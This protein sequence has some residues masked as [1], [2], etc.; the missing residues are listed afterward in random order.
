MN[1]GYTVLDFIQ[2]VRAQPADATDSRLLGRLESMAKQAFSG[3]FVALMAPL[4]RDTREVRVILPGAAVVPT[5]RQSV[6][7]PQPI[8]ILGFNPIVTAAGAGTAPD[9]ANIDCAIDINN[10]QQL[11]AAD[12]VTTVAG[13]AAAQFISLP[14]FSILTPRMMGLRVESP[15][16]DVGFQFRWKRTIGGAAD[17]FVCV[18]IFYR[19]CKPYSAP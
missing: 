4:A 13:G 17:A 9:V 12:G 18:G 19:Y 7:F 5:N 3:A 2:R 15:K 14:N 1:L 6:I 10:E 16:P 11:Q 8:E